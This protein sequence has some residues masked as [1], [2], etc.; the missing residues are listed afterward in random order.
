[1]I[2]GV[3]AGVVASLVTTNAKKPPVYVTMLPASLEVAGGISPDKV[4]SKFNELIVRRDVQNALDVA[5]V[6]L[7]AGRPPF[8]LKMESG[9]VNLE[10]TSLASDPSG[11]KALAAANALSDAAVALN[12]KM[13]GAAFSSPKKKSEKSDLETKLAKLIE[14]QS[15]EEAL[16]RVKLYALE[17]KLAQKSGMKPMPATIYKG[18]A[19]GDDVLRMFAGAEG[20]LSDQDKKDIIS[21]YTKL[22]GEIRSIQVKYDQPIN[23]I[24]SA[25]AGLSASILKSATGEGDLFPVVVVDEPAFKSLVAAGTHERYESKKLLFL[26]LGAMLGGMLGLMTFGVISFFRE[27]SARLRKITA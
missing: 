4:I 15:Q 21:E 8:K 27:N 16:P 11:L 17:S 26:I 18:S 23:E 7:V 24:A 5:H 14:T 25:F 6:G 22:V 10:V 12:K 2:T 19:I 3:V 20:K 9:D 13:L 1:L